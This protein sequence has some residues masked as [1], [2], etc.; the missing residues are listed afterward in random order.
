M[1]MFA[2]WISRWE[3]AAQEE[4]SLGP[5]AQGGGLPPR[6][7]PQGGAKSNWIAMARDDAVLGSGVGSEIETS[8]GPTCLASKAGNR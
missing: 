4:H 6:R 8:Q 2:C 1:R 3:E 7:P 5:P